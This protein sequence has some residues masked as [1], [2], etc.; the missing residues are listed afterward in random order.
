M[1]CETASLKSIAGNL[2]EQTPAAY[3]GTFHAILR[4]GTQTPPLIKSPN[5]GANRLGLS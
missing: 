3:L 2:T 5:K 1:Q 4:P